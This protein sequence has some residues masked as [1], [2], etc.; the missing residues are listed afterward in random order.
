MASS[1]LLILAA[2]STVDLV[3]AISQNDLFGKLSLLLLAG[4]SIYSFT[5]IFQ[6]AI[7]L[8]AAKGANR[9]FQKLVE[10]DG[11]WDTLFAASKKYA[12]SPV[13]RLLKETYVECRLE[14]WFESRADIPLD[15][16]LEIAN[17]TVQGILNRTLTA[18]EERLMDRL[19]VLAMI[20]TLAPLIG[21]FGTVWGVL[22][23]FQAIG[24]EGGASIS[25]LAPGISTAL[26]TTIFGLF[27][28]IPALV[29][30][31]YFLREIRQISTQMEA[32]S[33]DLE[34]AVRK[35]L[36]RDGGKRT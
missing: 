24:A 25:A 13:A 1:L 10:E 11:T 12:G 9:S 3:T 8:R 21:L 22:A 31:N 5:I 18:E 27:A 36:L 32:F 28:A 30:Y 19:N 14:N 17:N 6:K 33:H 2:A 20:T 34:N 15:T 4:L 35:Q 7:A 16:R 29:A 26:V 23:A